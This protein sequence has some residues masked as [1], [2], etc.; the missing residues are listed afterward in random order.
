LALGNST[1]GDHV[2]NLRAALVHVEAEALT[3]PVL[4]AALRGQ[5]DLNGSRPHRI[6]GPASE[7]SQEGKQSN[8]ANFFS[9]LLVR[10]E[11]SFLW[12][13]DENGFF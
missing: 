1:G 10:M 8:F 13:V 3:R 6:L 7:C 9:G 12:V 2:R 5:R 11:F 4:R